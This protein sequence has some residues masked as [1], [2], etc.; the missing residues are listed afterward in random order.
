MLD[1]NVTDMRPFIGAL[2]YALSREFYVALGWQVEYD[3]GNIALLANGAHRFY[4]QHYYAKEWV[5]NTM[6]HMT[7]ADARA[8]HEQVK[9]LLES[10]GFGT[11][12]VAAPKVEPYGALVTHVWDPA[13]VLLHLAQW[14]P[15]T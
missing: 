10:G 8:C 5:E 2:D 9:A 11:A 6:L 13:G 4:L 15:K 7:V 3:D 14:L 1:L 12:R